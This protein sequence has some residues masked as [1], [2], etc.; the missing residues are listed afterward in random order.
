MVSSRVEPIFM[1]EEAKAVNGSVK[2]AYVK[3]GNSNPIPK[4]VT[5]IMAVTVF[6]WVL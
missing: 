2:N 5:T 1:K 4:I 3:Y 6:T